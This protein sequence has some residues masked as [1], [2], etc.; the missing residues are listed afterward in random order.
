MRHDS[1]WIQ[2]QINNEEEEEDFADREKARVSGAGI[3]H[4]FSASKGE[5]VRG[6]M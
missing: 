2:F 6:F 5:A 3:F 1:S 4:P